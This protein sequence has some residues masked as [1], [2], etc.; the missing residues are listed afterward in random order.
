MAVG[1][2]VHRFMDTAVVVAD[3]AVVA[4]A[5]AVAVYASVHA[6]VGCLSMRLFTQSW[7][8]N[9]KSNIAVADCKSKIEN[10]KLIY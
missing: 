3:G 8:R 7:N 2:W 6:P 1:G 5:V 9:Q 4:V 10:Q